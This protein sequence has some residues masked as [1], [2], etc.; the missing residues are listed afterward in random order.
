[1]LAARALLRRAAV[2]RCE[3]PALR[4][5]AA[6]RAWHPRLFAAPARAP[7]AARA[8]GRLDAA[9]LPPPLSFE[10]QV[11]GGEEMLVATL[12]DVGGDTDGEGGSGDD[13]SDGGGGGGAPF[14]L[15]CTEHADLL[16]FVDDRC[17]DAPQMLMLT[18]TIKSG[19]SRLLSAVLPGLLAHRFAAD[20]QSRRPVVFL[21]RFQLPAAAEESAGHLV[22][23]LRFF[24]EAV[25]L[26][27]SP[28][29]NALHSFPDIMLLVARHVRANGGELWFLFDEL[30]APLVA[31]TPS[32]AAAFI[33]QL[34]VA[35]EL[36][37][38]LARVVGTGSGM[39]SLLAAVRDAPP[40][41]F[42]LWDA[43]SHVC[44]GREPPAPVALAMA[45]RILAGRARVRRWPAGFAALLTPQRACDELARGS[46]GEL[47]S[48]RPALVAHLADAAGN[49]Q[50]S[51]SPDVVLQLAI[52]S[53]LRKVEDEAVT[54]AITALFRMNDESRR[55]LR[56]LAAQDS[57]TE[58]MR[59]AL[60]NDRRG[61]AILGFASKLCEPAALT[62]AEA[63]ELAPARLLP[64]YGAL[65]RSLVTPQGEI[66]VTRLSNGRLDFAVQV[67]RNLQLIA[68]HSGIPRRFPGCMNAHARAAVSAAVLG[69]LSANGIGVAAS[70]AAVRPPLS[71]E[72]VRKVPAFAAVLGALDQHMTQVGKMGDSPSLADLKTAERSSPR[73]K[74]AFL[75]D[76]GL[77]VLVWLRHVD[78][79][80]Y[81]ATRITEG[82]GLSAAIVAAA[83]QAAAEALVRKDKA[84]AQDADGWLGVVEAL[85]DRAAAAASVTR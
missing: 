40:N 67:R 50:G 71:V 62:P 82:T 63:P 3:P 8:A 80:A 66:A 11:V 26:Q 12:P 57:T 24:A 76:L 78:A 39:V 18:G 61:R 72:E 52:E 21:H 6:A 25:G 35:V 4:R 85:K 5:A 22:G 41:G 69:T 31:S 19:K 10:A 55:W 81:F 77:R 83:V 38:P 37:S 54:D 75:A 9:V 13:S 84:F 53:V 47:T 44:L 1:M 33:D 2:P 60:S 15:T 17:S 70:G 68:E 45:E 74:T 46:H 32:A 20:P 34:K 64:P 14:F 27:L 58:E 42:A 36:C 56:R 65:L 29:P 49:A 43:V 73:A 23:R 59:R 48:P 28:P 16:R 51:D 79:H 7:A 30:Q